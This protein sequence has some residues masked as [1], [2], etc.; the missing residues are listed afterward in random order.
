MKLPKLQ[1][2]WEE[3]GLPLSTSKLGTF[4]SRPLTISRP[5][6]SISQIN[7][8]SEET[9]KPQDP[10]FCFKNRGSG[11]FTLFTVY[12]KAPF[13]WKLLSINI[14]RAKDHDKNV[15][16]LEV[17]GTAPARPVFWVVYHKSFSISIQKKL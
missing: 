8:A 10:L 14:L 11:G 4:L 1:A 13:I 6:Y 17:G 9:L 12:P 16:N 7:G 5:I 3:L 15:L 2:M